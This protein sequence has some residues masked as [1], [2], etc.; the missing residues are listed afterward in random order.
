MREQ[1]KGGKKYDNGFWTTMLKL[2]FIIYVD[3][4]VLLGEIGGRNRVESYGSIASTQGN[5][6]RNL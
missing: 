3:S 5:N 2:I 6:L 1:F 4:G